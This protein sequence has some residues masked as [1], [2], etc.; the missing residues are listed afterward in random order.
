MLVTSLTLGTAFAQ[1]G[2][3]VSP[4]FTVPGAR[5]SVVGAEPACSGSAIVASEIRRAVEGFGFR[6]PDDG[7]GPT[8]LA[9]AVGDL[10]NNLGFETMNQDYAECAEVC[11]EIP[12]TATRVTSL[13]GYV[14]LVDTELFW[15]VAFDRYTDYFHWEPDV[16][17]TRLTADAR[18]VCAVVRNWGPASRTGFL[19]VGY[20]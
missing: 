8:R 10:L 14:T 1:V 16:D 4:Y 2:W 13:L 18:L 5:Y 7:A 19:V 11:A 20:E 6:A 9:R 3:A 12:L 17:T 15:P